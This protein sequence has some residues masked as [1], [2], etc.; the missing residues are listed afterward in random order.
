M[1]KIVVIGAGEYSQGYHLPSLAHYVSQY[2]GEVQLAALCDLRRAHA[3]RM[4][5]QYGFARVYTNLEDMLD[6]ETPDGCIAVTPVAITAQIASYVIRAGVS[7][8][9]EKPPGATVNEAQEIVT[10]AEKT[11]TRV[12]VSMNRRFDPA[13]CAMCEWKGDRPFEYLRGTIIRHNR[14]EPKFMQE[15][16]IHLL[17]AIRKIG[18]NVENYSVAVRH[19]GDVWWYIVK[20]VFEIG[21]LGVL[22]V[23][24]NSGSTAE[25]Y[26]LFGLNYVAL[27]RVGRY[28]SGEVMC[29]EDGRVVFEDEPAQGMPEYIRNG[30]YGETVEFISAIKETRAPHPSPAEVLQSVELCHKIGQ[31]IQDLWVNML[32]E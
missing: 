3:E 25:F 22:E 9:M 17:D 2:P 23:L 11:G 6:Q 16:A 5:R 21:A 20:L 12:M 26:E 27:A 7:L 32:S 31:E 29:W 1:L 18:G 30:T 14:I 10:L 24:Q 13:L 28:D 19:V 8:L 15:T 4:A